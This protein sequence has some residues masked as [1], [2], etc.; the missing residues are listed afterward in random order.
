MRPTTPAR[1][2]ASY[3]LAR[4]HGGGL[5]WGRRFLANTPTVVGTVDAAIAAAIVVLAVRA[6]EATTTR[7][8]RRGRW[9]SWSCGRRCSP[10]NGMPW[11]R[12]AVRRRGS[13]RRQTNPDRARRFIL[14]VQARLAGTHR[15][16]VIADRLA[17]EH[18]GMG[19]GLL[20]RVGV[21]E[22][23]RR[24]RR[25]AGLL[26]T[27]A[28]R[29]QLLGSS[30]SPWMN[31]TGVRPVAFARWH[32]SSSCSVIVLALVELPDSALAITRSFVWAWAGS[33]E[34]WTGPL[35]AV[36]AAVLA[37]ARARRSASRQALARWSGDG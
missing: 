29:S 35:P 6:V 34:S 37:A 22:P 19:L 24:Q 27:A 5:A 25:V 15:L 8:S 4:F 31:T 21:V 18:L 1:P 7:P 32:C 14:R 16:A 2:R 13:P 33:T 36:T 17:G 10:W 20:D 28:Q 9:R 11:T 3:L 30:H 23:P 12:C 26:D